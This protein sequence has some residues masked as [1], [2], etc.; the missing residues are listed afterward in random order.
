M[1]EHVAFL[2]SDGVQ[3]TCHFVTEEAV[4][5]EVKGVIF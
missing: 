4:A 2:E 3:E 1:A 5:Q